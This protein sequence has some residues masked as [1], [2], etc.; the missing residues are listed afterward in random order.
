MLRTLVDMVKKAIAVLPMLILLLVAAG[1]YFTQY[2][3]VVE[4]HLTLFEQYGDK[5]Q[6][7]A[8]AGVRVPPQDWGEFVYPRERAA[9]F[10]RIV[11]SRFAGRASL[12]ALSIAIKRYSELVATPDILTESDPS[13][14]IAARRESLQAAIARTRAA[15]AAEED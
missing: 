10:A 13:V 7:L 1:C 14:V 5:L 6:N 8:D 3:E 11:D 2:P 15:L 4:T 12:G 9:D